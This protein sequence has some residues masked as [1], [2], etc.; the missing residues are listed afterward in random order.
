MSHS[1]GQFFARSSQY[2][3]LHVVGLDPATQAS[4]SPLLF[5]L[6]Q[7]SSPRL[8]LALRPQ[9]SIPDWIT[10]LVYL[11]PGC[12]VGAQGRKDGVLNT[13]QKRALKPL[14]VGASTRTVE[15]GRNTHGNNKVPAD[16]AVYT[17]DRVSYNKLTQTQVS[18]SGPGEPVVQMKDVII[19]YGEKLILGGWA[20]N[21]D[22]E[23]RVGLHWTV[24]KGE[25]WG[26]FGPNGIYDVD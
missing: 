10:H 7:A 2:T 24:R 11:N 15:T 8:L 19:K 17:E 4:L 26:V 13:L 21:H 6:A 23:P 14:S 16:T 12:R 3:K 25:R 18:L 1:V 9:D 5:S 22:G 20:E